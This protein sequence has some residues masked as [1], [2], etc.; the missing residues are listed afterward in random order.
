MGLTF[1]QRSLGPLSSEP[2]ARAIFDELNF[3]RSKPFD[4]AQTLKPLMK[5]FTGKVRKRADGTLVRTKEGKEAVRECI[6]YL[7][8]KDPEPVLRTCPEAL[9]RAAMDH[10]ENQGPSGRAGH[11]G[12][13]GSTMSSRIARHCHAEWTGECIDYGSQ[14]AREIVQAL[15]VDD[16]VPSRGHR[17]NVFKNKYKHVGIAYGPHK[18]YKCMCVLDF[19]GVLGAKKEMIAAANLTLLNK[20]SPQAAKILGLLP[21]GG[22][23]VVKMVQ[24]GV[25]DADKVVIMNYKPQSKTNGHKLRVQVKGKSKSTR[26]DYS[27]G[28]HLAK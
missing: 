16:G 27:W 26:M 1:A 20:I 3:C 21:S 12:P 9:C 15:L 28:C 5:S 18:R 8:S 25:K 22:K 10:V 17:H 2:I 14:S 24:D 11:T 6:D 7:L 19:A 13:D 23:R 4:Y